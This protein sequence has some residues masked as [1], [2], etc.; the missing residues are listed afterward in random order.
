MLFRSGGR[1][2]QYPD[3]S[4]RVMH[5]ADDALF[6]NSPRFQVVSHY[7]PN[8]KRVVSDVIVQFGDAETPWPAYV[9]GKNETLFWQTKGPTG[10]P[11]LA[12]IAQT[13]PDGTIRIMVQRKLTHAAAAPHNIGNVYGIVPGQ[14][15]R[16]RVDFCMDWL[17]YDEGGSA[18]FS[19][20]INDVPVVLNDYQ[21]NAEGVTSV[22][23]PTVFTDVSQV[24]NVIVG[25]Y[26]YQYSGV[27]A[28]DDCAIVFLR[29]QLFAV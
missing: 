4:I 1:F 26:R 5:R 21:G 20:E 11:P 7:L 12:L 28:P 25:P 3:G 9:A 10:Q 27:K 17:T 2:R 29:H 23:L 6:S 14:P 24:Y 19:I 13:Q 18:F 16:I 15:V 8:R 22:Y